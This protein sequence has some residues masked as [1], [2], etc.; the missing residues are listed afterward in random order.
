M[1]LG[2]LVPVAKSLTTSLRHTQLTSCCENGIAGEENPNT[3]KTCF[4]FFFWCDFI[5]L[6]KRKFNRAGT[7]SEGETEGGEV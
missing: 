2:M 7:Q 4:G 5:K 3:K 1:S 6:L